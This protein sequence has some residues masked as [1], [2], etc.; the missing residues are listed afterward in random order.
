MTQSD[1]YILF[2]EH[3]D[4][5]DKNLVL[6]ITHIKKCFLLLEDAKQYKV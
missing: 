6:I 2:T 5:Y 1:R 4:A 3:N